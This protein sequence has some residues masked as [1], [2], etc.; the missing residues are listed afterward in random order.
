MEA[1][2]AFLNN[3]SLRH[4]KRTHFPKGRHSNVCEHQYLGGVKFGAKRRL[5]DERAAYIVN[6]DSDDRLLQRE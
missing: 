1:L 5:N 3:R 2:L 6:G 4:N